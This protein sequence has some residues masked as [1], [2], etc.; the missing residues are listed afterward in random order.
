MSA[1]GL[2]S[3]KRCAGIPFLALGGRCIAEPVTRKRIDFRAL[4]ASFTNDWYWPI[5]PVDPLQSSALLEY[6]S[7][8][9]HP[10]C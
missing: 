3:S 10:I 2:N 8:S 9:G 5:A 1:M 6:L 4:K 7:D